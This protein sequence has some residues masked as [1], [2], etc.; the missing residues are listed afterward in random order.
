MKVKPP[1][2]ME[3]QTKTTTSTK[4]TVTAYHKTALDFSVKVF[5]AEKKNTMTTNIHAQI[6]LSCFIGSQ[7]PKPMEIESGWPTRC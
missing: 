3:I 1:N 2:G 5:V 4:T 7:Q 6:K